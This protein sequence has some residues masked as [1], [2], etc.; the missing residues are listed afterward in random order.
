MGLAVKGHFK[1]NF[2]TFPPE[3]SLTLL[4]SAPTQEHLNQPLNIWTSPLNIWTIFWA[5]KLI[6][7]Y[8]LLLFLPDN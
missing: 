4:L 3:P 6:D 1:Y 5:F 2:W 8:Q 7:Q